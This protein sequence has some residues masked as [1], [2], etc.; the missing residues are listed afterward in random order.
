MSDRAPWRVS[1][2]VPTYNRAA[3]LP[4]TIAYLLNQTSPPHEVIIVDDG[5][6][7]RTSAVA[8]SFGGTVRYIR[9]ENGGAPVARNVGAAAA[10]GDWLWFCDSDDLWRPEYLDQC[11]RIAASEARP[12][13]L[14][15]DFR[16]VR[17]GRWERTSKFETA[18]PGFWQNIRRLPVDGGAVLPD[19]I[20]AAILRF[21]PVFHSTI[22]MTQ[23]LFR[24]IGGYNERFAR[25]GSEDFEFILR[26]VE[27]GP[28]GVVETPLVGI[29]RHEGNF[30]ADQRK[31]LLGEV[32]I[33]RHAKTCHIGAKGLEREIDGEIRRR[34]LE[35]LALAFSDEDYASVTSLARIVAGTEVDLR[36]WLK[37]ALSGLPAPIRSAAVAVARGAHSIVKPRSP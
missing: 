9:T 26:C 28:V 34:T 12:Q 37:I 22:V 33:L 36:S 15:G 20:Y 11:R 29:R 17:D 25:T 4:E 16:L 35:A 21:Q 10:K 31:I 7:D 27:R 32:E 13:F 19:P 14:F 23:G 2:I 1:A 5:S 6:T 30:S 18:P 3:F 24:E 8:R